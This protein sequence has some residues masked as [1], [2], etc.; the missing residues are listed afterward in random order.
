MCNH[1]HKQLLEP[2]LEVDSRL[3]FLMVLPKHIIVLVFEEFVVRVHHARVLE[4]NTATV[5][6]EQDYPTSEDVHLGPFIV[7]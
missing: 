2:L 7:L 5:H 3:L 6:D 4:R 1:L